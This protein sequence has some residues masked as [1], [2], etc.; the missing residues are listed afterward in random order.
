MP[1]ESQLLSCDWLRE[2]KQPERSYSDGVSG[3]EILMKATNGAEVS[4]WESSFWLAKG[5][6]A[7]TSTKI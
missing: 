4:D 6:L 7:G 1:V 5:A 2:S 3:E